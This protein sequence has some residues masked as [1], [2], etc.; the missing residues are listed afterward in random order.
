MAFTNC[1]KVWMPIGAFICIIF[2][3]ILCTKLTFCMSGH[4]TLTA[5]EQSWLS[6]WWIDRRGSTLLFVAAF[7]RQ[8]TMAVIFSDKLPN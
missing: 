4:W 3:Q 8:L 6:F 2:P 7:M 5:G 1:Q